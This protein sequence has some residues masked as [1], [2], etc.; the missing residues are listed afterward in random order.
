MEK[1]MFG[2]SYGLMFLD[3]CNVTRASETQLESVQNVF[4]IKW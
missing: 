3:E 2:R 1:L 4:S